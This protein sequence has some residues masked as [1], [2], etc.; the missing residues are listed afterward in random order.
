M[1]SDPFLVHQPNCSLCE[2]FALLEGMRADRGQRGGRIGRNGKV[3]VSYDGNIVRNGK[4][5]FAN[6]QHRADGNRVVAGE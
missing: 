5:S 6:G 3:I 4:S 2:K 1:A